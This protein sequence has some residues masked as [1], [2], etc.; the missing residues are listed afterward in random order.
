MSESSFNIGE[1]VSHVCAKEGDQIS[2][3]GDQGPTA[4]SKLAKIG[5]D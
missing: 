1:P 5:V 2:G 3:K 4:L